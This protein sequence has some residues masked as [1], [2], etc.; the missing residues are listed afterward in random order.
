MRGSA[1]AAGN[2]FMAE[3]ARC[4]PDE[5]RAWLEASAVG[6]AVLLVVVYALFVRT[7]TGQRWENAV[8]A[9]RREDETLAAA[10]GDRALDDPAGGPV[11]RLSRF[12]CGRYGRRCA[13]CE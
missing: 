2:R 9:G 3:R 6:A 4:R 8:L 13:D 7:A 11:V 5:T 10:R 1:C 12:P